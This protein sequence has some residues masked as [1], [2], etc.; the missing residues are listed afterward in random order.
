MHIQKLYSLFIQLC[1][2]RH[3]SS[4]YLYEYDEDVCIP[5]IWLVNDTWSLERLILK[6]SCQ[7]LLHTKGI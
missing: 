4:Y 3:L 2:A 5:V 1:D 7:Q 6:K